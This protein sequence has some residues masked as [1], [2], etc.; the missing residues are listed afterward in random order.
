MPDPNAKRIFW[1]I[2]AGSRGGITAVNMS[3]KSADVLR[4]Q[5]DG[6]WRFVI[7]NPWGGQTNERHTYLLVP[8]RYYNKSSI[9]AIAAITSLTEYGND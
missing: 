9:A 2:F 3:A 6:T 8:I 4:H 1:Y 5:A 7:D